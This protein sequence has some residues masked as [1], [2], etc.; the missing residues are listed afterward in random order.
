MNLRAGLLL[1]LL[2]WLFHTSLPFGRVGRDTAKVVR[3]GV[4]LLDLRQ[5][6]VSASQR[7]LFFG[8]RSTKS[9]AASLWASLRAFIPEAAASR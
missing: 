5:S 7:V 3:L 1:L 6:K 4:I 9:T 2:Y 8:W